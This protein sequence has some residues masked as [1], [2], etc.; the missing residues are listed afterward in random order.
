VGQDG[1]KN[2]KK[3][4]A[5]PGGGKC[6]R[7]TPRKAPAV[8]TF[9]RTAVTRTGGKKKEGKEGL[10]RRQ[11]TPWA[12]VTKIPYVGGLDREFGGRDKKGAV[13]FTTRKVTQS[14][15]YFGV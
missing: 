2:E 15:R 14:K 11:E 6:I 4:W 13:H 7:E 9:A 1:D 3:T 5:Q 10:Y 8:S 12:W